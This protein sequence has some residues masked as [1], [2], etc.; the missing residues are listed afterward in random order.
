MKIDYTT[1]ALDNE[2]LSIFLMELNRTGSDYQAW[3]NLSKENQTLLL[4]TF[5]DVF[6]PLPPTK[7]KQKTTYWKEVRKL[8]KLQNIDK[9]VNSDKPRCNHPDHFY[10]KT[11][12]V[13]DHKVSIYNGWKRGIPINEIADI[14]NL[15]WITGFENSQKHFRNYFDTENQHLLVYFK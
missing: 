10:S 8:T 5:P 14:S 4:E 2:P 7:Y 3:I 12:Y 9:L 1:L 11:H 15:R 6:P 13:I